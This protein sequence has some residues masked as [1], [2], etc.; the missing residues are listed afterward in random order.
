MLKKYLYD[1]FIVILFFVVGLLVMGIAIYTSIFIFSLSSYFKNSVNERLRFLS[2][3]ASRLVTA[4]ELAQLNTAQD[5]QKPLFSD[6]RNR[7]IA[8][9]GEAGGL[10]ACYIRFTADGKTQYI[11]DSDIS[12][13]ARNLAAEPVETDIEAVWAFSGE[14]SVTGPDSLTAYQ[15]VYDKYGN[16]VAVAGIGIPDEQILYMNSRVMLLSFIIF[17]STAAVVFIGILSFSINKRKQAAFF[18]QARQQELMSE[19]SRSF[20]T[21]GEASSLITSALQRTGEFLDVQRIAIRTAEANSEISNVVYS[22]AKSGQAVAPATVKGLNGL[23][24]D[25][26][27]REQTETLHIMYCNNIHKDKRYGAMNI[28]RANAFIWAPLYV[29]RRFWAVLSIEELKPREWARSD[30]H[31]ASTVSSVIAGAVERDLREKERDAARKAAE[32]ASRAKSDFLANMSHEMRTPMNAIIGMTAI[33]KNSDDIEKKEYCL[34]KIENAS[35]HLLGVINDILDMSKIEANKFELSPVEFDFEKAIQKVVN[36]INFKVEEK[37]QN[38]RIYIDRKIPRVLF[39]DEQR[40]AQVIANLLSNAVKFTREGGA[41]SMEAALEQKNDD[42]CTLKISVTDTGI[43]ITPQQQDKLFSSFVQADSTTSRKFGGT[44][45]GLAISKRIVEMMGGRIWVQS[46]L[47]KGSSFIFTAKLQETATQVEEIQGSMDWSAVRVLAVDDDPDIR[48]YFSVTAKRIGFQC[49]IAASGDEALQLIDNN[50]G[51]GI[52]FVDWKMPDIDGIELTRKIKGR[53][54]GVGENKAGNSV[55][56]MISSADWNCIEDEAKAAGVDSFLSKPLFPS[57][58][59]DCICRSQGMREQVTAREAD[60]TR[61]ER[62]DGKKILLAE[63]MEIN[64]EIVISLLEPTGVTIDSAENGAVAVRRFTEAPDYYDMI[65][66]DVQ[67]PEMDG[68][69]ATKRIRASGL[70]GARTIP[71]IAMTANVFR[72]DIEQCI[73]AGMDGHVGKPLDVN[74][75]MGKLHNY[76]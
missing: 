14:P 53:A 9:A 71:I 21:T 7:L 24:N 75:V 18:A 44:G 49:D 10:Y 1:N 59:A 69:E 41:I 66:M 36:V 37:K 42:I 3:S 6:I 17:L 4:E 39:G 63:D 47:G 57:G 67:M 46:E 8:F 50:G 11:V 31:L 60:E 27:P 52:Y 62:F 16:P 58:I 23:F 32:N 29:E 45:L 73:A 54:V 20:I 2:L 30:R 22:W 72:E 12:G 70:P 13:G 28:T 33:A 26:F 34:N 55:I 40:L 25:T 74:E 61:I 51:Y 68:Y 5:I 38:F 65:F 56:I 35:G 19:L 76:L 64:R 48:E 43:G 15:A